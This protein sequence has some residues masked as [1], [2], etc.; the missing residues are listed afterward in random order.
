MKK[1]LP[2][3]SLVGLA[4]VIVPAILYLAETVEKDS[5][6]LLMLL[7]SLVWFGTAPFWMG[8]RDKS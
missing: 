3:V 5:M 2:S 1:L 6:K 7:G 4:L 8:G